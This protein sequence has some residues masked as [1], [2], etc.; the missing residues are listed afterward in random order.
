M[1][2]LALLTG[3]TFAVEQTPA[4][5]GSLLYLALI[6]SIV[7]FA[8]YFSLVGRIGA[9]PAAYTTVMFPLIALGMSTLFEGYRWSGAAVFGL[10]LIL[11]GN[12]VMFYRPAARASATA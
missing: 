10:G 5:L 11:I 1:L 7:G 3:A 4:Y 8:T 6:G 9:G 2:S 12:L